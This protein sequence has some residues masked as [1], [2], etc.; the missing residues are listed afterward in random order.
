MFKDFQLL[1]D[2]LFQE[3]GLTLFICD[4]HFLWEVLEASDFLAWTLGGCWSWEYILCR[5][6]GGCLCSTRTGGGW[7]GKDALFIRHLLIPAQVKL[8]AN[9]LHNKTHS[10]ITWASW[11]IRP[12]WGKGVNEMQVCPW[13]SGSYKCWVLCFWF[14]STPFHP[15]LTPTYQENVTFLS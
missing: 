14:F 11:G 13:W 9:V 7:G 6:L 8:I 3:E 5:V 10:N 12:S 1:V 2:L 15:H 4:F